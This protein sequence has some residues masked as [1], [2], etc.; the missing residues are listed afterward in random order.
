MS[1]SYDTSMSGSYDTSVSGSYD[2][3][4]IDSSSLSIS[5]SMSSSDSEKSKNNHFYQTLKTRKNILKFDKL[6]KEFGKE[7]RVQ[8]KRNHSFTFG[9]TKE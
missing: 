4:S 8:I 5:I 6:V 2:T 3:S 9:A 1:S 7:Y